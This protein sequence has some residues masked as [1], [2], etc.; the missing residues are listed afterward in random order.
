VSKFV[1]GFCRRPGNHNVWAFWGVHGQTQVQGQTVK[2]NLSEKEP[3]PHTQWRALSNKPSPPKQ[4][5]YEVQ[6]EAPSLP[7]TH[8][9]VSRTRSERSAPEHICNSVISIM[10][11]SYCTNTFVSEYVCVRERGRETDR[12]TVLGIKPRASCILVKCSFT[13][14]DPSPVSSFFFFPM[15]L[16]FE[17]RASHL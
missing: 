3:P 6:D 1:P 11:S 2:V 5:V 8:T 10:Q 12:Q 4:E 7:Y 16:G 9:R 15:G 17:L 13:E 14:L